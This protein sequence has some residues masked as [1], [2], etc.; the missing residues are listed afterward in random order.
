MK[1]LIFI[2]IYIVHYT[3]EM[4]YSAFSQP[5]LMVSGGLSDLRS[6]PPGAKELNQY[7]NLAVALGSVFNY[8]VVGILIKLRTGSLLKI[9]L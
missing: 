5:N 8:L 4:V 2:V 7:L 1:H 3:F 6:A 9:I